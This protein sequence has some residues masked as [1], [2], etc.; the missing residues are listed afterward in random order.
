MSLA[1]ESLRNAVI[2]RAGERCEYCLLTSRFQV[3]GF[4]L[5]HIHPVSRSGPT[6]FDNLAFACPVC[7]GRKLNHVDGLDSITGEV[8]PLFNP[9]TQSWHDRRCELIDRDIAGTLTAQ[10]R[11]ELLDLDRQA[12]NHF[13][14]VAPPPLGGA[15]RLH[16]KL[17]QSR[18]HQ[19]V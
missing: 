7:N 17:L 8:V 13:D 5:D 18:G 9:R 1:S 3:G 4:E 12:N 2:Q 6:N 10:E 11:V 15:I 14:E 16:Q 19:C